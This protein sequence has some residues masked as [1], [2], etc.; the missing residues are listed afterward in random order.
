[1]GYTNLG[2]KNRICKLCPMPSRIYFMPIFL[3]IH[4]VFSFQITL[5]KN[6]LYTYHLTSWQ[7]LNCLNLHTS[8]ISFLN[9]L[10]LYSWGFSP[11][12]VICC[13]KKITLLK[14][15]YHISHNWTKTFWKGP[16]KYI[17]KPQPGSITLE[18]T[19][20][21][22]TLFEAEIDDEEERKEK[23]VAK[24]NT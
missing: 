22:I 12:W 24:W 1:M 13:W 21:P 6:P 15:K 9:R 2:F 4:R 3:P 10:C 8:L 18:S 7:D 17:R 23:P 14:L 19:R 5:Q 20:I 16:N 11:V